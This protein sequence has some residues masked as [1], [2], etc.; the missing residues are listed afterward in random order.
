[1]YPSFIIKNLG[2]VEYAT[3]WT[4]MQQ[5]TENRGSTTPDEFWVLEHAPVFTLGLAGKEEHLL[6]KQH[7]IPI[8]HCDR[9]GQVTYHGPGQVVIYTLIDLKR[10]KLSIRDL[11]E[12]LEQGIISY[13]ASLG[14]K[15]YG[16]RCAPGVY[17]ANKKIASL[18]LKVRKGC[19]YHGISFNVAMD[20]TPFAY[21]NVCGYSGLKVVQLSELVAINPLTSVGSELATALT[22]A[23]YPTEANPNLT[24][25]AK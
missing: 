19:T 23:I 12:R 9:G 25:L 4:D 8:I 11:V 15:A 16:D 1:M 6:H 18:G 22:K 7:D 2:Q 10:A 20:T 24:S 5:F 13:L 17:I 3:T 21:I 14:I